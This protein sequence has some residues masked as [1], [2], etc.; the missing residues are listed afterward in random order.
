MV[1]IKDLARIAGV[2]PTTVSNILHGRVNKV[3]PETL[4]KVEKI[5]K[6]TNYVPNMGGRL[7]A[8]HGSRII[9]V[10]ITYE[11]RTEKNAIQDPFYSEIIGALEESIREQGYFMM[12][13]TSGGYEESIRIA[14]AWNIEGLIVLGSPPKETRKFINDT[15]VPVVFIDAYI[16]EEDDQFVNV[17]LQDYEGAYNMTK[18]LI[19]NGHEKIAFFADSE[20]PVG[21]DKYRLNG[22]I[23][24]LKDANINFKAD[25]FI[26]VDFRKDVRHAM[27]KEF[28]KGR[29]KNFTA[30]FFASDFYAV[31]TMN[32]FF[33]MGI[34][35]PEDISI[36]GFDNNILSEQSRPKLT[37]V[38]QN[39]SKK[40]ATAV[41]LL[42]DIIKRKDIDMK[43]IML[44][45]EIVVKRSVRNL[46]Q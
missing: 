11:I 35:T 6:E 44:P 13:Y 1:T 10:I 33:E 31:D 43:V 16:D 26:P 45:T 22:Y 39:V 3:S 4:K 7:L 38:N 17:G 42:L 32:L 46:N 37:T 12:L 19:E 5:I 27:L 36:V 41:K 24:A 2:S 34:S 40:A 25:W 20:N 28:A 14:S 15:S 23:Q 29:L 21:V 30:L 18:Y 9:G 8:K